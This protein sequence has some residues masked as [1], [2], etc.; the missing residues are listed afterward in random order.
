MVRRDPEILTQELLAQLVCGDGNVEDMV[1][2][3]EAEYGPP[4]E[5][6]LDVKIGL[7]GKLQGSVS[8]NSPY[9]DISKRP[10]SVLAVDGLDPQYAADVKL[11]AG[12]YDS[13]ADLK[14]R[15]AELHPRTVYHQFTDQRGIF[16]LGDFQK[17]FE[18]GKRLLAEQG[19][20]GFAHDILLVNTGLY[21]VTVEQASIGSNAKVRGPL[22]S[23]GRG[24]A[25]PSLTL[26][27]QVK[28][29]K[30]SFTTEE[31]LQDKVFGSYQISDKV[32]LATVNYAPFTE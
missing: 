10:V 17:D 14:E 30:P 12:E 7:A 20:S 31:H 32:L 9:G 15:H 22:P 6:S 1:S 26:A 21:A 19:Q 27:Q 28:S 4:I 2:Q 5:I 16:S 3:L 8:S 13:F 25:N 29:R 18:L 11:I 24:T 23:L